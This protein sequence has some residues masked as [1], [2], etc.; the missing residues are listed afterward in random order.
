MEDVV[1]SA[2]EVLVHSHPMTFVDH[3]PL[4]PLGQLLERL[5]IILAFR[6]CMD[7]PHH[8][9]DLLY[10]EELDEE[11]LMSQEMVKKTHNNSSYFG[12]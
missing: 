2:P 6:M 4:V 9:V 3:S 11:D 1:G 7:T 8:L 5:V 10:M 12:W